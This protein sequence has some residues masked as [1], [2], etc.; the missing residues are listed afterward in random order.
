MDISNMSA[1]QLRELAAEK[2][3]SRA[4]LEHDYLDFVQDK[5]KYAPYERVIEF[6]GEEYVVDILSLVSL[7]VA[8]L[9]LVTQS[10]IAQKHFLLYLLSTT[11]FLAA[12]VTIMLWKS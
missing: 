3:N 7:C 9:V 1:E 6:E 12:I 10:K 2:E 8:W 11:I 5:H 4:K